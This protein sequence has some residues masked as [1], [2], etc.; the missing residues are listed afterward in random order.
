ML[1][2][3]LDNHHD[4]ILDEPFPGVLFPHVEVTAIVSPIPNLKTPAKRPVAVPSIPAVR[5]GPR[6]WPT[7][8]TAD[9]LVIEGTAGDGLKEAIGGSGLA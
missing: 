2:R 6:G 8:A 9:S 4:Q 5:E 3:P 1:A 7:R